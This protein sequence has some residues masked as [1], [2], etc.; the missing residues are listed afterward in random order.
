MGQPV[1]VDCGASSEAEVPFDV[2]IQEAR[3]M[4]LKEKAGAPVG[5]QNAK[6]NGS[7]TTIVPKRSKENIGAGPE[8]TQR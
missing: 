7:E 6:N 4:P 5:N 1:I 8:D 2:A 3:D